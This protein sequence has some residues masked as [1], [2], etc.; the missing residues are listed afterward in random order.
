MK[1]KNEKKILSENTFAHE[2]CPLSL[3][4]TGFWSGVVFPA[5]P[6]LSV[7]CP[8]TVPELSQVCPRAENPRY[9]VKLR[10]DVERP[11]PKP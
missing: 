4:M 10:L 6:G 2:H 11:P 1:K 7:G 3:Y 5:S 9:G 8:W